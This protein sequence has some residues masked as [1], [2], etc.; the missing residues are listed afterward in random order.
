M[1]EWMSDWP[2]I[3]SLI[4]IGLGLIGLLLYLRSKKE[5]D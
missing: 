3:I 1:P 2:F 5:E 4:V